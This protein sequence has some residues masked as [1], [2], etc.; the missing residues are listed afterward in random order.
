MKRDYIIT[1]IAEF[2]IRGMGILVYKFAATFLGK[3]GFSQ[4]AL[5]RRKI[6]FILPLLLMGLGVGIP[7]YIAFSHSSKNHKNP[8][9]Y[10]ISGII[11]I[12]SIT[13]VIIFLLLILKH[14][15]AFRFSEILSIPI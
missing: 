3:E 15:F 6:S 14:S 2:I 10:F 1:F 4:Y 7:R 8:D 13:S 5:S 11:V 12:S 9:G